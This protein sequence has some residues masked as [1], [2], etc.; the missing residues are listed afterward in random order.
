MTAAIVPTV[1][2]RWLSVSCSRSESSW[3]WR[4]S[5]AATGSA[6]FGGDVVVHDAGQRTIR[7][8]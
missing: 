7:L 6:A 5:A 3:D 1:A 8:S 4:L 2:R